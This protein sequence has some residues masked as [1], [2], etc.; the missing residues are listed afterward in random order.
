[1]YL[2]EQRSCTSKSKFYVFLHLYYL[3]FIFIRSDFLSFL[4]LIVDQIDINMCSL[5]YVIYKVA[6]F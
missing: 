3:L 4:Y 6:G 1:M 2:S 5:C